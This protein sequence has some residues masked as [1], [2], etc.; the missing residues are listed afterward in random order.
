[1]FVDITFPISSF[2]TFVYKIPIE[3]KSKIQI[4]I[5]VK[6]HFRNS[7]ADGFVIK[8]KETTKYKGEGIIFLSKIAT[9]APDFRKTLAAHS[10][11]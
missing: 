11:V 9:L 3:L 5:R 4:G 8:I 6:V 2:K 10:P 7:E 1:M